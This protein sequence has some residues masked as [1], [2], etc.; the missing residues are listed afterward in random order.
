VALARLAARLRS[1]GGSL[2]SL[3]DEL[4]VRHGV[5]A[6]AP[7]TLRVADLA[8]IPRLMDHLRTEPPQTLAGSAVTGREDLSEG[9]A[10]LPATDALVWTTQAGDRVIV[11]PSGTE[12]KLKCYLEVIEPVPAAADLGATRQRAADRLDRLRAEVRAALEL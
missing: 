2:Q 6:T 5:H 11:R 3:L 10:D 9:S 7:V 12:P 1:S 4:A 8:D